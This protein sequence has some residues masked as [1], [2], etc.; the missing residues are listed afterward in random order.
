WGLTP[1]VAR[2][3]GG[4]VTKAPHA[5]QRRC[6]GLR[7][8]SAQAVGAREA[9]REQADEDRRREADDVEV[10]ALDPLHEG[11]AT[12]LDG[13]AAGAAL[14]L[15]ARD[16]RGQVARRQRPE[17]DPRLVVCDRLPAP[18]DEREARDDLVRTAGKR[19]EHRPRFLRSRRLSVDP[20]VEHDLGVDAEDRTLA[21]LARYRSRLPERVLATEVDRLGARALRLDVPRCDHVEGKAQLLEDRAPLRRCR[22]EEERRGR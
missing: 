17:R 9:L 6:F 10:V 18:R 14:P 1:G 2:A 3:A 16:V 12:A 22:S 7:R 5:S 21:G 4:T 13:L 8:R 15:A 19:L 11:G 20:S